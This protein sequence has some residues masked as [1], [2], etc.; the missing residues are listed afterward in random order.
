MDLWILQ[1]ANKED[2]GSMTQEM[3]HYGTMYQEMVLTMGGE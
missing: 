3:D 1:E 2:I